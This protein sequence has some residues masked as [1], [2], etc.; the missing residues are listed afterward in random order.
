MA[1]IEGAYGCDVA[2]QGRACLGEA[3]FRVAVET[4]VASVDVGGR[5]QRLF[6]RVEG[7]R[8]FTGE[9]AVNAMMVVLR[10]PQLRRPRAEYDEFVAGDAMRALSE[11]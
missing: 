8:L 11:A 9:G 7:Y 6:R 2:E 1:E 10:Q 3:G 4:D 5:E